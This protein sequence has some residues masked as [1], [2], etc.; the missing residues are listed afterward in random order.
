[1]QAS[2]IRSINAAQQALWVRPDCS[3]RLVRPRRA[4]KAMTRSALASVSGR[5]AM[6]MRVM[7]SAAMAS[8][9]CFSLYTSRWLEHLLARRRIV[10]DYIA[11]RWLLESPIPF[12]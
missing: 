6:I 12:R 2:L 3:C 7:L 10:I 11:Q 8:F 4:E 5:W 9:T 1:M